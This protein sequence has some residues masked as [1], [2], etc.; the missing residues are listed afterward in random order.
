MN[1]KI[2]SKRRDPADRHYPT[3]QPRGFIVRGRT[4]TRKHFSHTDLSASS[5]TLALAL[6]IKLAEKQFWAAI[7]SGFVLDFAALSPKKM[8]TLSLAHSL[9]IRIF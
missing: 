2:K 1:A 3:V 5:T 4:A 7:S 8:T 6:K 9:R